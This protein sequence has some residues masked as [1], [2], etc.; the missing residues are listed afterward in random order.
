MDLVVPWYS[1]T[2]ITSIDIL[3]G[4]NYCE[5]LGVTIFLLRPSGHGEYINQPSVIIRKL[6]KKTKVQA[7]FKHEFLSQLRLN[8]SY[9][10]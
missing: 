1:K 2:H 4:L 7:C 3:R 8:A 9:K 5:G 10:R 6:I